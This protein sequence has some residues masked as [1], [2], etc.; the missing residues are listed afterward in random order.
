MKKFQIGS[1]LGVALA[2]GAGAVVAAEFSVEHGSVQTLRPHATAM[3]AAA[4]VQPLSALSGVKIRQSTATGIQAPHAI[5]T[6]Q[7]IAQTATTATPL[8]NDY[9][10][11]NAALQ[12]VASG[13]VVELEGTF[14]W[15]ETHAAAS[16]ALGSD[17]IAGSADDYSVTP[18]G[19]RSNITLT[20]VGPLGSAVIQ[21]PGDLPSV[22]LES[23]LVLQ[24]GAYQ[25]WQI[26]NLE[27]RGFDLSL[28]MFFTTVTDFNNAQIV[29]NR[30][31]M[32]TDLA[33]GAGGGDDFQNIG[34]HL[35][36]G[37]NQLVADNE[38]IIPGNGLSFGT[39][40]SADIALQSNTSGGTAYEGLAIEN[41]TV[42]ISQPPSADPE[43]IIGIWENAHAHNSGIRVRGNRVEGPNAGGVAGSR[44]TGFRITSQ[45]SATTLVS[46]RANVAQ[47]ME[48]GFAWLNGISAPTPT[49]LELHGNTA[50]HNAIGLLLPTAATGPLAVDAQWNRIALNAMGI[51]N[52]AGLVAVQAQRNWWGCNAGPSQVGCDVLIGVVAPTEWLQANPLVPPIVVSPPAIVPVLFDVNR[53]NLGNDY[54]AVSRF[55]NGTAISFSTSAGNIL[56]PRYTNAG[57]AQ[58][59]FSAA[60]PLLANVS[61][62]LDN[63]S[64]DRVIL[65]S[66]GGSVLCVPS[67]FD[68]RCEIAFPSIQSAVDASAPGYTILVDAGVYDEQLTIAVDNLK[69]EGV[70]GNLSIIRPSAVVS[71]TTYIS[72]GL[73]VAPIVLVKDAGVQ[74][75]NL[76]L[77]GSLAAAS[78]GGCS[79]GFAGIYFRNSGGL[80]DNAI[81]ENILLPV[82][83]RGCQSQLAVVVQN[84]GGGVTLTIDNSTVRNY[85][86]NGITASMAGT[87]L[88]VEDSV[89][90]GRGPVLLGDAAQNGI[91]IATGAT[92]SVR[93]STIKGH[94]YQ[95]ETFSST[96][97]LFYGSAANAEGNIIEDNQVGLYHID[98]NG[99]HVGNT[100]AITTT[101]V[102]VNNFWGAVFDDPMPSR[103]PSPV[104]VDVSAPQRGGGPA[105]I[106]GVFRNNVFVSD[107]LS[108]T[109]VGLEGDAGYGSAHVDLLAEGNDVRG[110]ATG[111]VLSD[112]GSGGSCTT[113][114]FVSAVLRCNR[115]VDNGDGLNAD[116][117]IPVQLE[118]NWWGCNEG[119]GGAASCNGIATGAT[120]TDADPWMVLGVSADPI[121]IFTGRTSALTVDQRRNSAGV[122]VSSTCL[123]P[124]TTIAVAT[125]IGTLDAAS[126]T[127][128]G[129][130]ASTVFNG[131]VAG[132]ATITATLDQAAPT[133][134]VTVTDA[135]DALFA[136][137]FED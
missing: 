15:T 94:A 46:Y 28:A 56:N 13:S 85:G 93:N 81:V 29:G 90:E 58:S 112:C 12:S 122:D 80:L 34:I 59:T 31:S 32:P 128:V 78:I 137:G 91:Q 89:V 133:A 76:V 57:R 79:P 124:E 64:L 114:D 104:D 6:V 71:N 97:L 73:P 113:S 63:Q 87:V 77:D 99:T 25:G 52:N 54:A 103:L 16:W 65:V 10:R 66:G 51:D 98:G 127:T 111:V 74:L 117:T 21:G 118:N 38:I 8:D 100:F 27:V 53:S 109:S 131:T 39:D 110:F 120:A 75:S 45:P 126:L 24:A 18:A 55:P 84:G 61:A 125:N 67:S 41:N 44:R 22:D 105:T 9:I 42:Q 19:G 101:D 86:K 82:G 37:T 83:F 49:A 17:A 129:G 121:A 3:R 60:A 1:G 62:T 70:A 47:G 136:N 30:I 26:R 20:A 69:I 23:F 48:F 132:V 107:G 115:I 40:L 134:T 106:E 43:R 7:S 95:P 33:G 119:P 11:I 123:L 50:V 72:S 35:S 108:A 116:I 14:D 96:G 5:V 68:T 2:L 36:F 88:N 102:G 4:H 92:G 130:V 135:P